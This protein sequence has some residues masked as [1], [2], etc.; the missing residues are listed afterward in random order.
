MTAGRS[1]SKGAAFLRLR[2]ATMQKQDA[3]EFTLSLG[4]IVA[5]SWRQ[6][7]LAKRLG[8]PKALG[9][10]VEDWVSKRL[11]GYVKMSV[12]ERVQ[13]VEELKAEGHNNVAIAEVLGVDE[14][15]VRN[16]KRRSEFSETHGKNL[17][18]IKQADLLSSENSEPVG[19]FA[20][21][22]ADEALHI[23]AKKQQEREAKRAANE[24][25]KAQPAAIPAGKF[26]TVVIDP[27]WDMEK[28]ERDVR[29]N[30][31]AF[32]YP[33]MSFDDLLIF[34]EQV[35]SIAA[36]N[37]HLF[38]WAT[39]RFLP[40]ALKLIEHWGFRYVL[41]MVWHKPGGFQPIGLPQYNCEFVLYARLGSPKFIDTKAFNC[42][43]DGERRE[44]SRKPDEF[45][46]MI[47]RVTDGPRIDVFSREQHPGFAQF[48]NEVDKFA[49]AA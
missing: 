13:A 26:S 29:P 45:Y 36:D 9:L 40:D 2:E 17:N 38:M 6:I 14:G 27:P 28:I 22:A 24:K 30:Q 42:C 7:A 43:F 21:L 34:G 33:T 35:R 11:G 48:G 19:V 25:L 46:D 23:E 15:T 12:S 10:S 3:E 1:L 5:G 4:Q 47:R 18:E 20:A 8:V 16:D 49:G 32:D 44:H 31:A 41:A 39:Q 37:C